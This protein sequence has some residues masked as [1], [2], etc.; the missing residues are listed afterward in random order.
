MKLW[1]NR[2]FWVAL[3]AVF[4]LGF[5]GN[6]LW[7]TSPFP[8]PTTPPEGWFED[9][10]DPIQPPFLAMGLQFRRFAPSP[11]FVSS[12]EGGVLT[13]RDPVLPRETG[14]S[15]SG[16][17]SG[18]SSA[19]GADFSQVFEDVRISGIVNPLGLPPI[20]IADDAE[21]QITGENNLGFLARGNLM[22]MS[23]YVGGINFLDGTLIITKIVR[24]E[25]WWTFK[26][27]SSDE[28]QGSQ[29]GLATLFADYKSRPYYLEFDVRTLREVFLPLPSPPLDPLTTTA[30]SQPPIVLP[31]VPEECRSFDTNPGTPGNVLLEA[32]LYD[33]QGGNQLLSVCWIDTAEQLNSG[34]SGVF[35]QSFD[36]SWGN[37]T[38]FPALFGS[39]DNVRAVVPEPATWMTG[40]SAAL[41]V[42]ILGRRRRA[43]KS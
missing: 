7:A 28:Q 27:Q 29:P 42:L 2:C 1:S 32:R 19:F 41:L 4:L 33:A 20:P 11:T 35:V 23:T 6:S 37:P 31:I 34:V 40:V 9:F 25:L 17:P 38:R 18:A 16:S 36:Y 15:G 5:A 10:E 39:F 22:N 13:L 14:S 30:P 43:R 3:A 21:L 26:A 8:P 24:G 12:V